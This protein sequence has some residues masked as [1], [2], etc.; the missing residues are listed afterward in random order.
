MMKCM[1]PPPSLTQA[2]QQPGGDGF[3]YGGSPGDGSG[4]G[5]G[6]G[7]VFYSREA[8]VGSQQVCLLITGFLVGSFVYAC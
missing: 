7:V 2:S 8:L 4:A 1:G 6:E 3:E 5:S